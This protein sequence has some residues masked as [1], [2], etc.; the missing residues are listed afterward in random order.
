VRSNR[1][2]DA[3]PV[4]VLASVRFVAKM[5]A[6]L[7]AATS[8]PATQPSMPDVFGPADGGPLPDAIEISL[9]PPEAGAPAVTRTLYVR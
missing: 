7:A 2:V 4:E 5:K 6:P 1:N 8:R 9:Q 3:A